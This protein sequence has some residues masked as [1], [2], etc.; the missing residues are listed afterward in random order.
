M[1]EN[2]IARQRRIAEITCSFEHLVRI[3]VADADETRLALLHECQ[4]GAHR[5]LERMSAGPVEE[6]AVE[7]I[8]SQPLQ[9]PVRSTQ[10]SGI[11]R[12]ARQNFRCD[13]ETFARN[14]SYR[15]ADELLD[16]SG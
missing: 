3:E 7:I 5:F 8:T 10:R 14:S 2:L 6:I 16:A 1:I 4:K 13:E 15:F 9:A 12:I 11:T